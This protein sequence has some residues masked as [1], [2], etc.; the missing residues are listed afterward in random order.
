VRFVV[1]KSSPADTN[2]PVFV[3]KIFG[4]IA[5]IVGDFGEFADFCKPF[6]QVC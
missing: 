4:S 6:L 2:P 1:V 5:L 3:T